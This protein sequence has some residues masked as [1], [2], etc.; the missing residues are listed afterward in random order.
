MNTTLILT[1][2]VYVN[3]KKN[4][5]H[6]TKYKDRIQTYLKSLNQWLSKTKFNIILVENSGY[7][8][9]ELNHEKELYKNRFEVITYREEEEEA[10]AYLKDDT[11]KGGSEM[12]AINYAF[13]HSRLINTSTFIIK[14]T[15]RFYID[16]LEQYLSQFEL[17]KYDGLT[18]ND[19]NRCEMVGC[20]YK[21][22]ADIF[23]IVGGSGLVE[24]V[25]M[26]RAALYNNILTCKKFIIERTPRGGLDEYFS[27]I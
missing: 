4:Y 3:Y 12:F 5:L 20:H 7:E 9:H 1:S 24:E 13:R 8:F 21:N 14:I 16:E 2:T 18:Q 23:N 25:W 27:D 19:K 17:D 26:Y 22:F 15:A 10:A 6:Q 11:F